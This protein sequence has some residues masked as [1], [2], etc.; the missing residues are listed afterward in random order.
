[1]L[2]STG[3]EMRTVHCMK[4]EIRSELFTSV[5]PGPKYSVWYKVSIQKILVGEMT[6]NFKCLI[7]YLAYHSQEMFAK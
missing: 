5:S 7:D 4:A 3:K 2:G 6:M 1:M